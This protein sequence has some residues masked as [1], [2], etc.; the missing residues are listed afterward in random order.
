M[1]NYGFIFK[2][3]YLVIIELILVLSQL[4]KKT[5]FPFILHVFRGMHFE[6]IHFLI[7]FVS[8]FCPYNPPIDENLREKKGGKDL[9]ME[10][11]V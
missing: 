7:P 3:L 9:I 8:S 5:F 4:F 6:P 2:W 11:L 1:V 10:T